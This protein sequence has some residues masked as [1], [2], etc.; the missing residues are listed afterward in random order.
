MRSVEDYPDDVT[1][2]SFGRP[3]KLSPRDGVRREGS[4]AVA[5]SEPTQNAKF[6]VSQFKNVVYVGHHCLPTE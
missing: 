3:W 2:P 4:A 6:A 1:V 5:Y